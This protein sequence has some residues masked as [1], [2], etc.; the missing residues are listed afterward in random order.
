MLSPQTSQN[1]SAPVHDLICEKH[2]SKSLHQ[3]LHSSIPRNRLR[4]GSSPPDPSGRD[5]F[6]F[7]ELLV[8]MVIVTLLA[9]AL[10]S[11]FS[12]IIKSQGVDNA[13]YEIKWAVET[14]RSY[15]MANKTYT[16][17]GFFEDSAS[18]P[19]SALPPY[20]GKGC[21][22]LAVVSSKDGTEI[23]QPAATSGALPGASLIQ[24]GKIVKLENVHLADVA[25]PTGGS[26]PKTLAGRPSSPQAN[27]YERISSDSADKTR[28]PFV[29]QRHTFYKTLQF[30]PSGEC[31]LCV[32]NGSQNS[33]DLQPAIEIGIKPTNGSNVINSPNVAAVQV[34]G[35]AGNVTIFRP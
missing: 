26:D 1:P 11:S 7:I 31:L 34:T 22:F 24:L 29:A 3:S 17:V 21:V 19:V 30:S 20:S 9:T 4:D 14:A 13:A 32:D 28:F 15:A 12:G 6:T 10:V 5:A 33:V 8:V 2:F 23:F 16:W 35:I 25:A 18:S 27:S